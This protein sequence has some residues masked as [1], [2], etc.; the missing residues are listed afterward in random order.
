MEPPSAAFTAA[1]LWVSVYGLY[2][3]PELGHSFCQLY[4]R[5]CNLQLL[6]IFCDLEVTFGNL[7]TFLKYIFQST[8]FK[9]QNTNIMFQMTSFKT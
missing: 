1:G 7:S 6:P 2:M 3:E 5:T 4:F 9:F 8:S